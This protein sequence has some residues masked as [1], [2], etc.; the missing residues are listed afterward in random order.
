MLATRLPPDM[1]EKQIIGAM[2][3]RIDGLN[4]KVQDLLLFARPRPPRPAAIDLRPILAEAAASA[5]AA[6]R[7]VT[8]SVEVTGVAPPARADGEMLRE[9]FLN[10][11][12]NACQ[13]SADG[14]TVEV[15]MA[16][17]DGRCEIQVRDR[18]PGIP[19][20]LREKIFTPFFTTKRKG[21]GL[22]LPIV[23]RLIE[24]QDGTISL[25]SREGGGTVAAITLPLHASA[26]RTQTAGH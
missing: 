12:L 10:L 9:I 15:H 14:G 22:G 11:L 21:T 3:D 24:L 23:K 20:D 26:Q 1:R 25:T 18:G 6:V 16:V 7:P 5:V 8:V 2:I 19:A 4:D 13:A 17:R